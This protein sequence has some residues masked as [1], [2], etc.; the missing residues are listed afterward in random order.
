MAKR[1]VGKKAAHKRSK[2]GKKSVHLLPEP[3]MHKGGHKKGHKKVRK[4]IRRK[5]G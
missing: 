3:T 4:S 2:K 5:K 1:R